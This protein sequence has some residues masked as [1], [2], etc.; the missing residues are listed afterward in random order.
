MASERPSERALSFN[1]EGAEDASAWLHLIRTSRAELPEF[2]VTTQAGKRVRAVR[3]A[4]DRVSYRVPANGQ[5]TLT[6]A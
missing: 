1:L 6:W 4:D 3:R 5:I 2:T